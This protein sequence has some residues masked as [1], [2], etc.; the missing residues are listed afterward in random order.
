MIISLNWLKQFTKINSS[1][2]ELATLIGARLVEVEEVIDL[3]AKYANVIIADVAHV[4]KHPDAD[5]LHVVHI[6][7]GGADKDVKRLKSGLVEVV[8]GAPNVREGIKVAW[9]PPG[10]TVPNTYG[11]DNFV[12]E[13]RPLRGVTSNGM[14]ASAKELGIGENHTGI[15]E[16]DKDV[17]AGSSFVEV[18]ELNDYLLDIENKSLTHRPDCFGLIGFAREVAAIQGERF[19]SPE[20]LLA[21]E[22][23]LEQIPADVTQI[24]IVA[25][26]EDASVSARYQLVAFDNV[27]ATKASPFAIQTWLA[28]VGIRPISAVVD[29]TNYLMYLTGQPLHAFDLDK[30]LAEHS[31]SKAEIIVRES[32]ADE[33]LTLLDGRTI[34]LASDDIVICAGDKPI[35]LAGAMG[36]AATEIDDNT[37]RVL[38]ESATFDLYRLR[39]TQMRHGIFSEAVTRFTKGQ[40]PV[41]TAPV[42]ASAVRMLGDVAGAQRISAVVD[43]YA[44]PPE[45]A[46]INVPLQRLNDT[47]GAEYTIETAQNTLINVECS[48]DVATDQQLTVRPPYWRNDLHIPEDIIEEVGRIN[49]FD[50]IVPMLPLRPFKAVTPTAFDQMRSKVRQALVRAGANEI[51]TYSFVPERLLKNAGQDPELAFK[52]TNALS[53]DLQ[54]YRLSLMP[55][56]LEKA[57]VNM[58]AGYDELALFEINK[59]HNKLHVDDA[60]LPMEFPILEMVYANQKPASGKG[61]AFYD[62]RRFLDHVA[63]SL[64]LRI[65]YGPITGGEPDAA[66]SKP[67]EVSRSAYAYAKV[68][69]DSKLLGIVGEFKESV[70]TRMKLPVHSA[71]FEIELESLLGAI[72]EHSSYTPLSRY[73][74]TEKDI[75]L[76]VKSN[77]PYNEIITLIDDAL[78]K[79]HIETSSELIDIYQ[80]R[81]DTEHKHFT[82]RLKL[83][84]FERTITTEEANAVVERVAAAVPGAEQV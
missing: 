84:N 67:Y 47:L 26:V 72:P 61:A 48:V 18:Y 79:E 8:C 65:Y 12:L 34:T 82:L 54:Y 25:H 6:D 69:G 60:G 11:K 29:I 15:V 64:G 14:L 55:S 37:T 63:E 71:G 1:V 56:L 3:G 33:K 31:E 66:V 21:V 10:A 57:R 13:A 38:L 51:L 5:K 19:A 76:R 78:A 81:D 41:Q 52:I 70:R 53:H 44:L 39:N 22:T 45:P 83:T 16:I 59:V 35:A 50:I 80:S 30:V 27:D 7:D 17:P 24:S 75:T 2:D 74:G 73:P 9:L 68:N 4:E 43:E 58:K 42:L 36:G 20:W 62:A 77:V 23:V 32:R 40:S 49:G 46:H 28:R